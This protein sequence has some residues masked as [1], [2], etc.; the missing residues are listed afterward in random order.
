MTP[1]TAVSILWSIT[2][3]LWVYMLGNALLGVG[4]LLILLHLVMVII[5]RIKRVIK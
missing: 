1:I 3:Q 4:I 2:S 5:D